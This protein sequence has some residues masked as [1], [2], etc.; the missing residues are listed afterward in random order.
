[1]NNSQSD[2]TQKCEP[3]VEFTCSQDL[4]VSRCHRLIE[5]CWSH[6]WNRAKWHYDKSPYL[7]ARISWDDYKS[8]ILGHRSKIEVVFQEHE[9]E[10]PDQE[11]HLIYLDA[12]AVICGLSDRNEYIERHLVRRKKLD[13]D[14]PKI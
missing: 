6:L 9:F 8:F 5:K 12:N 10:V 14:L 11:I 1:M 3:I 7:R 13:H 2:T 4:E